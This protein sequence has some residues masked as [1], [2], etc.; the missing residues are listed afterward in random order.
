MSLIWSDTDFKYIEAEVQSIGSQSV[1]NAEG[2]RQKGEHYLTRYAPGWLGYPTV[3][4]SRKVDVPQENFN[5]RPKHWVRQGVVPQERFPCACGR[6]AEKGRKQCKLCR[7][8]R[9]AA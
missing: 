4:E 5:N 9:K 8:T 1:T 2:W 7:S 3:Q 6:L